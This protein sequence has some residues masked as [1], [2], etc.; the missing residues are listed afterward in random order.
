M[1]I[2][3]GLINHGGETVSDE[4]IA[5]MLQALHKYPSDDSRIWR[6]QSIYLGCRAQWIT[7]ESPYERLPYYDSSSQSAITADAIIDNREEL[8]HQLRIDIERRKT[9]TDSELILLAYQKW[10][11][12]APEYLLGDFAFV[13]W[14]GRNRR[15]FGA[16]DLLGSRTLYYHQS[17]RLF[18][19]S[20]LMSPL[21][22]IPGVPENEL[23][24]SWFAEFLSIPYIQDSIDVHSTLYRSIDQVPPAHSITLANG[25]VKLEQYG[26]FEVPDRKL[27]LK[28]NSDYEDA[29][30][31]VFQKA[32]EARLRTHRRVGASLSGGLDSSAVVSFA[33]QRLNM[34]GKILNTYSYV[35]AADFAD[36][37]PKRWIADERPYIQETVRFVGHLNHRYCDFSRRDSW[38]DVDDMI[39]LMEGPYKCFENSFWLKGMLE[40][41]G[42]DDVG[43]L[44]NGS[45][46]NYTISWGPAIDYYT[47]LLRKLRWVRLY[48]ELKHYGRKEGIGRSRL[49]PYLIKKAFPLSLFA[50]PEPAIPLLVHPDLAARTGVMDK[51][52]DYHVGLTGSTAN[53]FTEREFQFHHLAV[54][55]HL[56]TSTTKMSLRYGVWERD[57]TSDPRVVRFCLSLPYDQFVQNGTDRSLI[58]RSAKH[59]IP[60]KVRENQRI[61]GVQGADWIH[62]MAPSWQ[63]LV[64]EVGRLC[65]DSAA[66]QFMN[67]KQIQASMAKI[68]TDPKPELAYDPDVRLIMQSIIVYRFLK[69]LA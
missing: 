4:V 22:A 42:R 60:D 37:T 10:G 47:L 11:K 63:N 2:I 58:R 56:G 15:F 33:A 16:R 30:R 9:M 25:R 6:D 67:V 1:S 39:G 18:A 51:L 19:F 13:I 12:R 27:K 35:P 66:S 26:S 38:T 24:E 61:R 21:L 40:Q 68:G 45:R 41:A 31:E 69:R 57:P 3:T 14:D 46:G 55:N 43:I 7:P 29:F 8:F 32:V 54:S 34:D 5:A 20:T 44:L 48:R 53:E 17:D 36:W 65:K 23:N 59:Y 64:E 52:L 50:K 28:N 62:R 49:V